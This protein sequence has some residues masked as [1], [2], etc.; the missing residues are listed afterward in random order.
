[1][2]RILF[3]A[4]AVLH[5]G[6]GIAFALLAFGCDGADP[7]LGGLCSAASPMKFFVVVTLVCW[8]VL[9]AISAVLLRR[10]R[11]ADAGGAA[12]P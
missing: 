9:G 11:A 3:H 5:L 8:V 1:M 2:L 7:A 12:S 4:L 10:A 6:P